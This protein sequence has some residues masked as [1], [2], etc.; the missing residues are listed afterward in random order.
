MTAVVSVG[1]RAV[2]QQPAA[3]NRYK[4]GAY[5]PTATIALRASARVCVATK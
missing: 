4:Q 2:A 5:L 3:V 1:G